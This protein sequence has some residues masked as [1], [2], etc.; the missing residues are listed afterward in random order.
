MTLRDLIH[1][2]VADVFLNDEEF[3][4]TF[5]YHPTGETKRSIVGV[6]DEQ[7]EHGEDQRGKFKRT[8]VNLFCSRDS[9]TGIN[10]PKLGDAIW[11]ANAEATGGFAFF[12]FADDLDSND[13]DENAHTLVFHRTDYY[14]IGGSRQQV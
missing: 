5:W 2:D 13:N 4:E 8:I 7:V 14:K 3:G 11:R 1:D 12:G 10:S 6:S 9:T